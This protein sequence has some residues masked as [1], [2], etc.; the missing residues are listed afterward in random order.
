MSSIGAP[1]SRIASDRSPPPGAPIVWAVSERVSVSG[2]YWKTI[3][4]AS[5]LIGSMPTIAPLTVRGEPGNV[6][7][8]SSLLGPGR[9]AGRGAASRPELHGS[10]ETNYR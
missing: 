4:L 6:V 8:A 1:R 10:W 2:L 7:I 5:G 9:Q 3:T